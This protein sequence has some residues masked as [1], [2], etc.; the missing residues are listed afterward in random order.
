MTE[1]QQPEA[2]DARTGP[3]KAGSMHI[4]VV[5]F[6]AAQFLIA[7]VLLF[8]VTPFVSG[9]P[10]GDTIESVLLT[11]VLLSGVMAV[12][13]RRRTL[14]VAAL[15]VLPALVGRW[16]NHLHPQ[17]F[18]FDGFLV[19]GLAFVIF[20]SFELLWFV[21]HAPKVNSEVLCAGVSN[22]LL[23]GLMWSFAYLLVERCS[24]GSFQYDNAPMSGDSMTGFDALYFSFVTLSTV[25]YGDIVPVARAA[26]V[27]AV[28]ESLT[29]TLFVAVFIAR[30]VALYT[31]QGLEKND[32]SHS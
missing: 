19:F 4:G 27:L 28:M 20:V 12:G 5:R 17:T 8:V 10:Y 24:P 21:L 32:A 29:G 26:R 15:L 9:L 23:L 3:G 16:L 18:H 31:S 11:L 1:P 13:W 2:D 7:L 25:G 14:I 6:S 30:L 22:Y